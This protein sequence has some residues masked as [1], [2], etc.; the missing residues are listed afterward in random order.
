MA[1]I[2]GKRSLFWTQL[3]GICVRVLTLI[4]AFSTQ[5]SALSK[6]KTKATAE[7]GGATR[8]SITPRTHAPQ[9]LVALCVLCGSNP[10][11]VRP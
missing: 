11:G 5:Q 1:V 4:Q 8:F 2:H 10:E 9:S 7:G 6:T 3:A